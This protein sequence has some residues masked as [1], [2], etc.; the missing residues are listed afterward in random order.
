MVFVIAIHYHILHISTTELLPNQP[1]QTEPQLLG[2]HPIPAEAATDK[3][4]IK[5]W[6]LEK[7]ARMTP[8]QQLDN[9]VCQTFTSL[10]QTPKP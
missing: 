7:K 3:H 6:T 4:G 9:A 1:S 8:K 2:P 10:P 5:V